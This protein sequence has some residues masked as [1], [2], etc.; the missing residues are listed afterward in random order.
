MPAAQRSQAPLPAHLSPSSPA[1]ARWRRPG[2]RDPRLAGGLA[3]I[4][5][6]V[7]L[8]AWA[9]DSAAG[10]QEVYILTRDVAPGTDLTADGVLALV[11]SRPGTGAYIPAGS[12]PG[13]AIAT[14]S[15]GKGE[16]LPTAAVAP[17]SAASQRSIVI[18]ASLGLP[19]GT[20]A[21]DGVDLWQLPDG[22][23]PR[24][25]GSAAP[26]ASA[27]TAHPSVGTAPA[28]DSS[29]ESQEGAGRA[30]VV[31]QGLVIRAVNQERTS[32]VSTG[33]T[34]V[35]V[36]VPEGS[37]ADVLTAVG[38]GRPLVLVPTGQGS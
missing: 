28:G 35:E 37:V 4:G 27:V 22:Q 38:S 20:G 2:W 12:L 11:D 30:R 31:A 14:R 3:L 9:V 36:L 19:K 16:L 29:Q 6:A 23:A 7:A 34:T 21:G 15:L 18:E 25:A 33:T 17:A 26:V 5:G 13:D 8:G 32:L 1:P 10:T 24:S